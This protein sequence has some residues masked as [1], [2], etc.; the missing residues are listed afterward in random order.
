MEHNSF[1]TLIDLFAN[2]LLRIF[3]SIFIRYNVL[4]FNFCIIFFYLGFC[5]K[6]N[7]ASLVAQLVKNPPAM[8]ESSDNAGDLGLI[9]G[10][11]RSPGEANGDPFQYSCLIIPMNRKEP[12]GLQSL[13]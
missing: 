4:Q 3:L 8:Q 5:I 13:G 9:T 6:D 1:Y 10:S 11:G 12:G 2:I 7:R